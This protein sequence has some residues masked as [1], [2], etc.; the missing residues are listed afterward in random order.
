MKR[1][2][3]MPFFMVFCLLANACGSNQAADNSA[4][5]LDTLVVEVEQEPEVT[6]YPATQFPSVEALNYK[7]DVFDTLH[8]GVIENLSDLYAGTPGVFTFRGNLM[9]N[10]DFGGRVEGRP[11]T[12]VVNWTFDTATDNRRTSV[13]TWGGGTGWTGQPLYVCWPD[14]MLQRFR[15]EGFDEKYKLAKQEVM[16]G[17]LCSRAYFLNFET[18]EPTRPAIDVLNPIKGT[19]SIDPTMNG[20]LYIGQGVPAVEPI[21]AMCISLFQ[22]KITHFFGRDAKAWRGWSAYDSSPVRM[23]RFLIR[24]GENG[25][26]YKFLVSNDGD[27]T[28][29]ST[30]RFRKKV[31]SGAGGIE[32]SIAVVANYGVVGDNHGNVVCVDLNTMQPVWYYDLADDIDASP[33]IEM[34]GDTP[35]VYVGCEVDRQGYSGTANFAKINVLNG[36]EVWCLR[37]PSYKASVGEKHFDGGYY[38]TPLIGKGNCSD[39]IFANFVENSPGGG[40]PGFFIAIN[41]KTGEVLYRV[42]LRHYAWSSPVQFLNEKNECFVL[43]AD[44]YGNIYIF[45]GKNGEE[46]CCLHIGSNFESSPVVEGNQIVIGS[47][48][49]TIYKLTIGNRK[50]S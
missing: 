36:Q 19:G 38:A 44:T 27:L 2:R 33:V 31:L 30:L 43:T 26:L 47:R 3:V 46:L 18:G 5:S 50:K 49:K 9:R 13:G 8:S 14:S 24:P 45:D 29:H 1:K 37:T 48:G 15:K 16:F 11:D 23:G 21:G 7:V 20:N 40:Q 10:A 12:L 32:C 28:L 4:D 41:K 25:T 42:R 22:H 6:P 35:Y 34:E 39:R 17:S